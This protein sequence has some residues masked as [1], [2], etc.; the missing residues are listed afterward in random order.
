[1]A[2]ILLLLTSTV[3]CSAAFVTTRSRSPSTTNP[4]TTLSLSAVPQPPFLSSASPPAFDASQPTPQSATV[5]LRLPLGNLFDGRDYI[6]VTE[7]NVRGYEWSQKQADIL[8]DDF[9]DAALGNFGGQIDRYESERNQPSVQTKPPSM[10]TDYELSQIVLVPTN[11]WDSSLFGLGQRFDVYDGQQR[12]VTLNLLLAGLRDSFQCE[13]DELCEQYPDEMGGKRAVALS[14]TANEISNMLMPTKV[15]KESV[16]RITLRKRDNIL[17]EKIL[18]GEVDTQSYSNMTRR[19][20]TALLSSLSS[21]NHRIIS[22]FVHLSTRL[23]ILSTRERLRLLDYIV[24]RVHLLV[25]IPENPRIARNIVMSQIKKG[26][27]NEPIDDF[28]GVICFRY[29]LEEDQMYRTFDEWEELAADPSKSNGDSSGQIKSVGRNIISSACLLRASAAL[30][31]KIRSR[32][33]DEVYEWE[34][35]LRMELWQHNQQL[36]AG[37]DQL[38]S[39]WQGNHFFSE[40]I[41]PASIAL[42]KFRSRLWDEFAFMSKNMT[43]KEKDTTIARLNFLRDI[44]ATKEAE[45]VIL[46]LLLRL[47]NEESDKVSTRYLKEILPLVEKWS[48]WMALAKPSP[49]QR[50]ARV[51]ALV[52]LIDDTQTI[53]ELGLA[54]EDLQSLQT[55]MEEY[56]FGLSAASKRLASSILKRLDAHITVGAMKNV[57]HNGVTVDMTQ[58]EWEN[59]EEQDDYELCIGNLA[60]ITSKRTPKKQKVDASWETKCKVYGAEPWALTR[61]LADSEEWNVN[62]IKSRQQEILTLMK[63]VFLD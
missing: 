7:S 51:F 26:L 2:T 10:V 5:T 49:M 55:Y 20:K 36:S 61:K 30:R 32:G 23:M 28:K 44:A 14:A 1:M 59:E 24:E 37:R 34:R 13:A 53:E 41:K 21:A 33:G 60:L 25:C 52:D 62:A 17:L 29:T 19:E 27:D 58:T 57:S 48:L 39:E 35:W 45:I 16:L 54:S 15:R 50:H 3:V 6:F 31:A 38:P 4:A 12:L 18:M 8:L 63:E 56:E 43:K 47:E 40:R 22:N 11:D 46:E 42:Y 9:I